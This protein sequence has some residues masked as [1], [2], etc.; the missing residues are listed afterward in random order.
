MPLS[1]SIFPKTPLTTPQRYSDPPTPESANGFGF[2]KPLG[3]PSYGAPKKYYFHMSEIL[4]PDEDGGIDIGEPVSF[5]VVPTSN[6][7]GIQAVDV[8]RAEPPKEKEEE[9]EN[10]KPLEDGVAAMGVNDAADWGAGAWGE[11]AEKEGKEEGEMVDGGEGVVN[12][13]GDAPAADAVD[14]SW[15]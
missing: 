5:K 15:F 2:I 3:P 12:G 11:P 13:A 9:K 6:N 14:E 4:T 7:K 8:Q 10:E 1:P